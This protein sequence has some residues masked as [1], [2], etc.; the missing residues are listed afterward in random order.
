MV[1]SDGEILLADVGLNLLS[2]QHALGLRRVPLPHAWAYKSPEELNVSDEV[3]FVEHTTAMDV[4][5]FAATV[6]AVC[7]Y[8]CHWLPS[9]STSC[10]GNRSSIWD[11]PS[12]VSTRHKEYISS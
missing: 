5:S 7:Y 8:S 3:E 1:A 2:R 11:R 9:I 6:Y 12:E 10:A 4:Y